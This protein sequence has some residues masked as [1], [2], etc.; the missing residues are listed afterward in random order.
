M[1]VSGEAEREQSA[2]LDVR[3]LANE[4]DW[5]EAPAAS[6]VSKTT[7]SY[8]RLEWWNLLSLEVEGPDVVVGL[9]LLRMVYAR[10]QEA[11]STRKGEVDR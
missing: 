1:L 2:D 7:P 6:V 8:V 3:L 4:C 11:L 10:R 9:G 5:H